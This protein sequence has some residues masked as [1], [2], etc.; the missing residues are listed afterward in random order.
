M[1]KKEKINYV[2]HGNKAFAHTSVGCYTYEISSDPKGFDGM[3]VVPLYGNLRQRRPF[4]VL[5]KEIVM[6]GD[7]NNYPDQLRRIL[8]ENNLMPELIQ[9]Q[10]DLLW[11]QGPALYRIEHND[12][13][14]TR[15]WEE[16][17]EIMS[18]LD[19]WD[20]RKYLMQAII[21]F[22]TTNGHF[23]K[24]YRNRGLRTG[25]KPMITELRQ[26]SPV[27]SRLEW[28]DEY[29]NVCNIIVGDFEMPGL[30][31]LRS[32]PVFDPTDPFAYPV[33]MSYDNM[34]TFAMDHEYP[35]AAWHGTIPWIKLSSSIV[36]VLNSFN[37]NAA[38][39][40]YHV[41]SPAIYWEQKEELLRK[42]CQEEDIEYTDDMLEDLK[43]ETFKKITEALS[44]ADKVGKMVTTESIFDQQSGQYVGWKIEALDQKVKDYIDA[45]LNIAERAQFETTSGAGVHPALSNLS[46][47]GNLP[48]GS[49]QLYAFKLYLA[50]GIDIPE[51]IVTRPFNNTLRSNFMGTQYRIGFYHENVMTE[52][53]TSPANRMK[54]NTAGNPAAT[55]PQN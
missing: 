18:W 36:K 32:Y 52:E 53:A 22:R 4:H 41:T 50:T 12:G 3:N 2:R 28:P 45:Q 39:I 51:M 31:G 21:N 29:W 5:D 44:G 40:K 46:K 24:Y 15:V 26:E 49:E 20:Y 7:G 30:L 25:R 8:D 13:K 1:G 33:S 14:R 38:A 27:F 9:K 19:T 55:V 42:Q 48:S 16:D 43:D 17:P 11:G 54:N 23:T 10:T 34:Y 47:D 37:L 35:R 6:Y